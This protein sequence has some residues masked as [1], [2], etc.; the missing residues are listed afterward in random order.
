MPFKVFGINPKDISLIV[1]ISVTFVPILARELEQIR[2]S[3]K[4]KC[5]QVYGIAKAHKKLQYIMVPWLYSTFERTN[6]LEMALKSR[7]YAE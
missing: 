4:A 7:G 1:N 5:L 2:I 3:L 6:S